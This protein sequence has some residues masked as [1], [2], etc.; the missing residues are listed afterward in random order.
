MNPLHF[1]SACKEKIVIGL[2]SMCNVSCRYILISLLKSSHLLLNFFHNFS[3]IRNVVLL[4]WFKIKYR[5][6]HSTT[7]TKSNN[8]VSQL[9]LDAFIDFMAVWWVSKQFG[10]QFQ[11]CC[12]NGHW[13]RT[14]SSCP[15]HSG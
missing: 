9:V 3:E 8:R 15:T 2:N 13:R 14:F 11:K 10:C 12:R 5:P 4:I 7:F 6:I 1:I